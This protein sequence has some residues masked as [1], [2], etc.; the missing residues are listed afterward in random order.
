MILFAFNIIFHFFKKMV[1]DS[2]ISFDQF[3]YYLLKLRL[4]EISAIDCK[5]FKILNEK[6]SWDDFLDFEK[7]TK[8]DKFLETHV[9]KLKLKLFERII[10]CNLISSFATKFKQVFHLVLKLF[11]FG[12]LSWR[13]FYRGL[14]RLSLVLP[15]PK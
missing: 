7:R 5:E 9:C 4:I 3:A 1:K 11:F 8:V 15:W 13:L 12:Q 10:L 14:F 2:G 6:I